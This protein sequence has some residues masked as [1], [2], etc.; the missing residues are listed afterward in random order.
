M[1]PT[2]K[3]ELNSTENIEKRSLVHSEPAKSRV[4]SIWFPS[5]K[6]QFSGHPG[7]VDLKA[8]QKHS[9]QPPPEELPQSTFYILGFNKK[10]FEFFVNIFKAT[11]Y[12]EWK[13]YILNAQQTKIWNTG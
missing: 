4:L 13:T 11:M 7:A 5:K 1:L 3:K 6:L 9:F 10:K 12:Q 2:R 8:L